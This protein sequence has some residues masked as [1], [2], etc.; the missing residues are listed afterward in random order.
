[1]LM[2]KNGMAVEGNGSG[3][4]GALNPLALGSIPVLPGAK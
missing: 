1:M 3:I 4:N 2:A